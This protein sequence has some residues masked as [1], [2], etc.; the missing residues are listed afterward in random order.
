MGKHIKELNE[1]SFHEDTAKGV[2]LVDFFADWCGPC[3]MMTPVLDRVAE[4]L[5]GKAVVAKLDIDA[6]EQT[7]R[8]FQVT[9]VP[10]FV[11]L[12]DGKEV[13]RRVGMCDAGAMKTF[14]QSAFV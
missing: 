9:S 13:G 14:I 6:A 12:R 8:R 3:K 11:L 5:E 10:T 7:A 4:E 1:S 2:I